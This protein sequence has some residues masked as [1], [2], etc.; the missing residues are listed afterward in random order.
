MLRR[1]ERTRREYERSVRVESWRC[2][3]QSERRHSP[4]AADSTAP[5]RSR[6]TQA[7]CRTA[8]RR[9]KSHVLQCWCDRRPGSR[10]QQLCTSRVASCRRND[11][12]VTATIEPCC[13]ASSSS[14][15][16]PLSMR[17]ASAGDGYCLRRVN[18]S[19]R[20]PTAS[21]QA[22]SGSRRP[23]SD[24]PSSSSSRSRGETA[25]SRPGA[26]RRAD[27]TARAASLE[28]TRPAPH[29]SCE[30]SSGTRSSAR[31]PAASYASRQ[32]RKPLALIQPA[33]MCAE[34]A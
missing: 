10:C 26:S 8:P 15:A 2:S 6:T 33:W 23:P 24:G 34:R 31:I 32:A 13:T 1:V 14:Q 22:A 16:A 30:S 17:A 3:P 4:R 25:I 28:T 5:S 7:V 9:L 11:A 12:W 29:A 20:P 21:A 18:N 27:A 19:A